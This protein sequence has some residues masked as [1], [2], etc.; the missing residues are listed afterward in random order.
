MQLQNVSS[1][2]EITGFTTSDNLTY[3]IGDMYTL[4]NGMI[5]VYLPEGTRTINV[6]IDETTY[7]G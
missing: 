7:S 6:T 3:E 4:S 5:Y 1:D 2:K